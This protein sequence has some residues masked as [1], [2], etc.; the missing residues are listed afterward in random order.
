M[1]SE[2]LA[3]LMGERGASSNMIWSDTASVSSQLLLESASS[4][5][6]G[7]SIA[8]RVDSLAMMASLSCQF[9]Y[10]KG[11]CTVAG[12]S[13]SPG[14]CSSQ[15]CFTSSPPFNELS[16][17]LTFF[18]DQITDGCLSPFVSKYA[19]ARTFSSLYA[20]PVHDVLVPPSKCVVD[21][22]VLAVRQPHDDGLVEGDVVEKVILE[23]PRSL[24]RQTESGL[25]IMRAG[26]IIRCYYNTVCYLPRPLHRRCS[27]AKSS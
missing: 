23:V 3:W 5:S 24:R 19:P 17:C 16:P 25:E 21:P 1:L 7:N 10:G 11:V 20:K 2:S 12:R 15:R 22:W 14:L 26:H 27:A 18:F 4:A 13:L 6:S 8:S 9:L